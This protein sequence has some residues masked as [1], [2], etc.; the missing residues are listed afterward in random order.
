V[1]YVLASKPEHQDRF[2]WPQLHVPASAREA[3]TLARELGVA[4][5]VGHFGP[6]GT[7]VMPLAL[8]NRIPAATIFHGYDVSKLLRDPVWVERYR[9]LAELGLHAVCISDA[10][11]RRLRSIGWPARQ[12]DVVHL[13]VD[14]A[15]LVVPERPP[16]R[17]HEPIRLLMVARLVPKKGIDVAVRAMASLRA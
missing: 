11:R 10:G 16:R 4:L 12:I 8:A 1:Q 6:T 14:T 5:A 2:P 17:P 13:G 3:W 15:R 7:T 9:G